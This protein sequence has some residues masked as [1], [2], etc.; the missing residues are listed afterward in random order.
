MPEPILAKELYET[1]TWIVLCQI[2]SVFFLYTYL[3][4][5]LA[6]FTLR[7][8]WKIGF[9]VSA[10][11]CFAIAL[12]RVVIL[13]WYTEDPIIPLAFPF[14]A[15]LSWSAIG[16]FGIVVVRF[17]ETAAAKARL[18]AEGI[19]LM[20]QIQTEIVEKVISGNSPTPAAI[21][22]FQVRNDQLTS[23]AIH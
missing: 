16:I 1:V 17:V 5:R 15:L 21:K 9:F 20:D 11:I 12:V 7:R 3:S 22:R 6:L 10:A 18:N 13:A 14:T 19:K 4:A 23:R 2:T 8:P